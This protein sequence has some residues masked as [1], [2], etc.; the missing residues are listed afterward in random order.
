MTYS[1][2]LDVNIYIKRKFAPLEDR[3]RSIVAILN[4]ASKIFAAARANLDDS[5]PRPMVETA[6]EEANGA[7]D[8]LGKDL[9]EA[10]KEVKDEALMRDFNDANK[11]A[12][13]EL[14][15]YVTYL[16]EQKLPKATGQFALGRQKYIK[17]IECGEMLTLSPERLLEIGMNQVRSDQKVF[18]EAARQID[19][20]KKPIEVF[21]AMAK[22]HP[23]AEG[24]IPDT[25]KN[26][27]AI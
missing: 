20:G 11:R 9:V 25:A 6:I 2:T 3:I 10:L 7:A 27:D 23:T 26:L 22:E 12:I 21:Q 17:L 18:A 13:D 15:G 16:K 24:L 8:F 19:P 1:T 5:L 4:Q 14:R